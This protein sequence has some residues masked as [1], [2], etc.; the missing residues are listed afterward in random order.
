MGVRFDL[1]ST[2]VVAYLISPRNLEAP[3]MTRGQ[4][5]AFLE[6]I[7]NDSDYTQPRII[8]SSPQLILN[9][10]R[11]ALDSLESLARR[12]TRLG[13]DDMVPSA[14]LREILEPFAVAIS[15]YGVYILPIG[16][17]RDSDVLERFSQ[18]AA[19]IPGHGILVLIPDYFEPRQNV[20]VL[21]PALAATEAIKNRSAWPGAIFML[22]SGEVNFLSIDE[23]RNRVSDLAHISSKRPLDQVAIKKVVTAPPGLSADK[24]IRRLLHLSDLHFGTSRAAETEIFVQTALKEHLSNIDRIVI[25][26]DLF[27]QPRRRDAQ[28]YRNFAQQLHLLSGKPPIIVPGNHDQRVFGNAILGFGRRLRQLADIRWQ[29]VVIEHESQI[30]FFCFDSSR[31]GDLARGCVDRHQ[32]LKMAT[33]Y[34]V[35]NNGHVLDSYLKV[36]LVHHH[37]YPYDAVR[38]TPIIDPRGWIGRESFIELRESDK[39]LAW[40]ASRDVELILHGHKH[41]PR[42]VVERVP[43]HTGDTHASRPLTTVG[44]GST[45]GANGSPMSFN[46]IEWEPNSG[47]WSARFMIDQGDGSGFRVA[48]L[49]SQVL[50]H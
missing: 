18:E 46:L 33:E 29:E 5:Q 44:C 20:Q 16:S 24:P 21:D 31:T 4:L 32:L 28:Q 26:G 19:R 34:E 17:W 39:F 25:T 38:E 12:G 41:I 7:A 1:S 42:L 2:N 14:L 47:N 13:Y 37:P 15:S 45:L 6:G 48:A 43:V 8:S 10:K 3:R 11:T 30:A 22:R 9:I 23:A 40:C 35:N 50:E 36:A 27:D 49:Q